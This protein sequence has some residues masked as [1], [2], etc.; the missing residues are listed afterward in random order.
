ML[1]TPFRDGIKVFGSA[2]ALR[3]ILFMRDILPSGARSLMSVIR[4]I[5]RGVV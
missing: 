5:E 3:C 4:S 1:P 2:A